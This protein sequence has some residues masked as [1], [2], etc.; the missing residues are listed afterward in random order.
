[1]QQQ[2][3][4]MLADPRAR[5]LASSFVAQW[6]DLD[7]LAEIE[8]DPKI[9]PYAALAGDLRPDFVREL[10]LF[11]D[12]VLREDTS[13]LRLLDAD[14][15]YLNERLA[16]HYGIRDVKG[17]RYRRV[18]LTDDRRFGLLGKGAVLMVSSYPNRTSPVLRGAW[19]LEKLMGTPPPVPPPDVEDL[20]ENEEGKPATTVRERLEQHRQNP[21]CNACHAIM[22]P[23][24]FALENFDATGRWRDIDRFAGTSIDASGVLP[25]GQAVNGPADLRAALL[26]RPELFA[27]A[28]TEKLLT[29]GL[30]RSLTAQDMPTVRAIVHDAAGADYRFAALVTGVVQSRA[31][32][33]NVVPASDSL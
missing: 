22:D 12:S 3:A 2:V 33:N 25:D 8:P 31:F 9:F 21:T 30:G 27:R 23:L 26:Q 19:V 16:L 14:H 15:T 1:M 24:G 6:L 32:L 29:Y 20:A 7:N 28:F 11:V 4:R 5:T 13:I 18:T 17:L 10:E